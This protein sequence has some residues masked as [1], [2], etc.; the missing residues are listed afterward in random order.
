MPQFL[1]YLISNPQLLVVFAFIA[2][3]VLSV[4]AKKFREY[5]AKQR[6]I[7]EAKK[8]EIERLR[9]GRGDGRSEEV[10]T[11][12]AMMT[13][14]QI[15]A[16]EI[17]ARRQQQLDEL[18]RRR[19]GNQ[20]QEGTEIQIGPGMV[21]RIP[22]S[23]GPTVPGTRAPS[24]QSAPRPSGQGGRASTAQPRTLEEQAR[25]A[26]MAEQQSQAEARREAAQRRVQQEEIQR[27]Q[28]QEAERKRRE[29]IARQQA[30]QRRKAEAERARQ[31][32]AAPWESDPDAAESVTRRIVNDT[33]AAG[34]IG[35]APAAARLGAAG[36]AGGKLTA[37]DWRRAIMMREI[38]SA[39]VAERDPT[40]DERGF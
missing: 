17:A 11:P 38:L 39:P 2:F 12:E 18:R 16:R 27:R 31:A 4:V 29:A 28:T 14:E 21:V 34:A 23:T 5:S 20:A 19:A 15:R 32:N 25:N 3:S 7:V 1:Q 24:R 26:R 35:A 6:A 8:L 9:T 10:E 13:P 33:R 36:G 22:G 40:G 30:E 37:A